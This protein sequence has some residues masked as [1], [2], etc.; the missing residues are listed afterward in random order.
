MSHSRLLLSKFRQ[1]LKLRK[2]S[3]LQPPQLGLNIR[4]RRFKCGWAFLKSIHKIYYNLAITI[5]SVLVAFA[6]AG[7]ELLQVI[8]TELNLVG[9]FWDWLD[10]LDFETIGTLIIVIFL[11]SWS[12]SVAI[13]RYRRIDKSYK[14]KLSS[15]N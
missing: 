6:I 2:P 5:I 3:W 4:L 1:N 13:W 14:T 11:A 8:A 15:T 7:I 10:G 12:M 9:A